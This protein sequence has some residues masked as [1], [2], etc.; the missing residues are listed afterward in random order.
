MKMKFVDVAVSIIFVLALI[1]IYFFW[2]CKLDLYITLLA[3]VVIV[4]TGI[5]KYVQY[6]K[7]KKLTSEEETEQ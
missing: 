6:K 4:I 3:G 7:I 1:V 5:S 2:G